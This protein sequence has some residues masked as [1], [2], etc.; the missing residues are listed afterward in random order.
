MNDSIKHSEFISIDIG[1]DEF[2]LG[3]QPVEGG[4]GVIQIEGFQVSFLILEVIVEEC[5]QKTFT[6]PSFILWK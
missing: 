1:I 6:D 2:C 3:H 5:G 4:V